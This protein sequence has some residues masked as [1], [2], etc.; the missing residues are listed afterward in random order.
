[1][2]GDIVATADMTPKRLNCS[3][4]R[5]L[6]SLAS[7]LKKKRPPTV[8]WAPREKDRAPLW[9]DPDGRAFLRAELGRFL[10]PD[11]VTGG[12]ANAYDYA[13]PDPVNKFDLTGEKLCR[14]VY[15]GWVCGG[16]AKALSVAIRKKAK[17]EARLALKRRYKRY[18]RTVI[19]NTPHWGP[20]QSR[21]DYGG[22]FTDWLGDVYDGTVGRGMRAGAAALHS[23]GCSLYGPVG[24][25]PACVKA[26]NERLKENLGGLPKA[27]AGCAKA[28]LWNAGSFAS[29]QGLA[30]SVGKAVFKSNLYFAAAQCIAGAFS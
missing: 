28:V 30:K 22:A 13:N 14:Q 12:S 9:G 7:P 1:M 6:T 27:A 4:P 2:H 17:R 19:E 23:A 16:N 11:P 15:G 18:Q 10:T 21:E 20:R 8:G 5:A 3:T 29:I 24:P 25:G 26:A